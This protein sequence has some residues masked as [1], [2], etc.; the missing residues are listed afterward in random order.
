MTGFSWTRDE[1]G[2]YYE[3]MLLREGGVRITQKLRGIAQEATDHAQSNAP[4][5][6]IT[7]RARAGLHS[8]LTREPD[9][10]VLVLSHTMDY[11]KWLETI[12]G[13]KYAIIM[14]TLRAIGPR[15]MQEAMRGYSPSAR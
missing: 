5:N 6:D 3:E 15:L 13:G 10:I 11:G 1:L 12:Q 14:P 8:E 7:G 2:A 4:W 9:G